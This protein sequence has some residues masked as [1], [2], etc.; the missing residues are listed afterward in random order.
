[1]GEP[2]CRWWQLPQDSIWP[3]LGLLQGFQQTFTH[4]GIVRIGNHGPKQ[5]QDRAASCP[6]P[7]A[8]CNFINGLYNPS[9]SSLAGPAALLLSC[10]TQPTA[11]PPDNHQQFHSSPQVHSGGAARHSSIGGM[12]VR[13]GK[14]TR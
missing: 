13:Q 3:Q 1:M 5:A 11:G 8:Q 10:R 14:R 2:C 9:V 12:F 4:S 6:A 7:P